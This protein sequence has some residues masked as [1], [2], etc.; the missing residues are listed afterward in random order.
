MKL[1]PICT[2]APVPSEPFQEAL[3]TVTVL[4]DWVQFPDQPDCRVWLPA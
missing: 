1:A 4:P 2:E 3:V